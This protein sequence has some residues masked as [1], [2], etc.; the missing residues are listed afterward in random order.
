MFD[1]DEY[2]TE[3]KQYQE[4][5]SELHVF[6]NP[7]PNGKLVGDCVKRALVKATGKD[8]MELQR[9]L[10]ALK[11]ITK[12]KKFN[13][14]K[15]WI[16]Y[17]EKILKATKLKGFNNMKIGEFA[18]SRGAK[19]TFIITCRGHIVTIENGKVYDTWNSS[20]KAIGKVWEI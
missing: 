15:N 5:N 4:A 14:N 1:Y 9:E 12:S 16:Y 8:Y 11:K 6:Y 3:Q 2:L 7:H 13:D 19:G 17:V 18:K 10:N 20:F